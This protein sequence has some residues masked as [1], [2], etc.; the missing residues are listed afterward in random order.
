MS[1]TKRQIARQDTVDNAIHKLINDVHPG[2]TPIEW[3]ME[4]I[5]E[6][7]EVIQKVLEIHGVTEMEFYPFEEVE[8]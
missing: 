2:D 8:A 7:R 4:Y 3:N 1:L 5:G 6:V